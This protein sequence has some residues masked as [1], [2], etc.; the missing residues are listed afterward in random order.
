LA[1]H[2]SIRTGQQGE[3]VWVEVQDDGCGIPAH[4]QARIFEPFYTTKPVG[5]GT[6]LG[7]CPSPLTLCCDTTAACRFNLLPGRE[8]A[9]A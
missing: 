4:L 2:I 1:S 5:Q 6:G 7:A 8:A 9:F 3:Q